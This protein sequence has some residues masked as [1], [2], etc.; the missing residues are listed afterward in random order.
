MLCEEQK[1]PRYL[2]PWAFYR[3]LTPLG[4]S[5]RYGYTTL[6]CNRRQSSRRAEGMDERAGFQIW[7]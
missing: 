6:L 3:I 1:P 5:V 2:C 7:K 4:L